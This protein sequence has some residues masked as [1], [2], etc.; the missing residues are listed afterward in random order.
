MKSA[1][2]GL[3]LRPHQSKAL[4][5]ANYDDAMLNDW[6]IHH[7]HL[8]IRP[9]ANDSAFVERTGPVL[10][11]YVTENELY[12]IDVMK[13]DDWARQRLLEITHRNWPQLIQH[14]RTPSGVRLAMVPT[15]QDIKNLRRGHDQSATQID[16]IA[17]YPL[18]GGYVTSGESLQVVLEHQKVLRTLQWLQNHDI[19][20]VDQLVE[21]AREKGCTMS[22]PFHFRL[23]HVAP[24]LIEVNEINCNAT[25]PFRFNP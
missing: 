13:H 20:T 8:G 15:D 3:D 6:R 14:Y 17:Y 11:A 4:L 21:D 1:A 19:K 25:F 16:G 23:K 5:R 18:G 22:P 12:A 7:F 9:D 24:N 2:K 10:F